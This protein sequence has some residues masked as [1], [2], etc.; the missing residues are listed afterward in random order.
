[1]AT[2]TFKNLTPERQEEILLIAYEEFALNGYN[3]AS[4]SEIIKKCKLA[5]GSFYRY[6]SSKKELYSYLIADSSQRRLKNLDNLLNAENPDF[7]E[8]IKQNFYEKVKFDFENPVIGGFLYKIMHEKDNNDVS[9]IISGLYEQIRGRTKSIIESEQ[10]RDQLLDFD[11]DLLAFQVFYMQL[12][13]YDYVAHIFKINYE[14]NVK[15]KKPVF[16]VSENELQAVIE[17][18]VFILKNGIKSQK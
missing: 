2:Q 5:K 6:F 7:F 13:L 15:N 8:M 1:M 4:L 3:S 10:F 14:E 9:D 17:K 12:W 16:S 18:A 11:S